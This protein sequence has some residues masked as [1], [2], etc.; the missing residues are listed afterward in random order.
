[1]MKYIKYQNVKYETIENCL[2]EIFILFYFF[3]DKIKENR[4][5]FILFD[6]V[7]YLSIGH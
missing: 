1:M 4:K 3:A 5:L 2:N 6:S 7:T